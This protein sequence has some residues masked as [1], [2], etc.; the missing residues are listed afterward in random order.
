MF[1]SGTATA[2]WKTLSPPDR[3][4]L[5]ALSRLLDRAGEGSFQLNVSL[6]EAAVVRQ[7]RS[8]VS[9]L[10]AQVERLQGELNRLEYLYRCE[11]LVNCELTDLCRAHKIRIRPSMAARPRKDDG[12]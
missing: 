7:L 9:D 12:R 2:R 10:E 5:T 1:S 8:Q 4:F 6:E 3:D 11:T